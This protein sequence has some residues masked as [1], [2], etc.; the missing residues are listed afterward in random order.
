MGSVDVMLHDIIL[1]RY[2]CVSTNDWLL[3]RQVMRM[4]WDRNIKVMAIGN[5]YFCSK[6]FTFINHTN[7][8]SINGK[9]RNW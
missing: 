6:V 2:T 8:T 1:D 3:H 5:V 9:L 7:G 4:D